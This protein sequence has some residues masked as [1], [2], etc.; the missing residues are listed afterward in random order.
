MLFRSRRAADF[1]SDED[2][3]EEEKAEFDAPESNAQERRLPL[4]RAPLGT[5]VQIE[6][7][8]FDKPDQPG[9]YSNSTPSKYSYG[10]IVGRS[11]NGVIQQPLSLL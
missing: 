1:V 8:R 9:S 11:Q 6:N 5:R 2:R 3:Q 7:T 4:Y 10:E